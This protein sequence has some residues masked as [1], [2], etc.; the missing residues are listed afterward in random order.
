MKQPEE[1]MHAAHEWTGRD[2][3]ALRKALHMTESRFAATLQAVSPRTVA[4][5]VTYPDT[6]PRGAAQ[7]ALDKLYASVSPAAKVRFEELTAKEPAVQAGSA[8]ALRV[9]I[10]VVLRDDL[11]LLVR[12]RSGASGIAWQFPAGIVKPGESAEDVAVRETLAETSVHCTA[13]RRIG[14]RLHPVTGVLCD[15]FLCPYLAGDAV[16][17]DNVENAAVA[18]A[19]RRDVAKFMEQGTIYPPVLMILEGQRDAPVR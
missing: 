10:A 3:T 5:W 17:L 14:G 13:T 1:L 18:W 2:A 4:N 12:R 6:V 9:A 8:Q 7:E 15:Y 19:P 16:N 11:V